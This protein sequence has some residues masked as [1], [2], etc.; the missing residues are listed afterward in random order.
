MIQQ[1]DALQSL[2]SYTKPK[3]NL[4]VGGGFVTNKLFKIVYDYETPRPY[5]EIVIM[6]ND[7]RIINY[8]GQFHVFISNN[9][10]EVIATVDTSSVKIDFWYINMRIEAMQK[11]RINI[12]GMMLERKAYGAF[13]DSSLDIE[14][15]SDNTPVRTLFIILL[16]EECE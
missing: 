13:I 12:N 14:K 6:P 2:L 9:K 11:I 16:E 7:D 5:D 8:A 1:R 15:I 4:L 3:Y 10:G